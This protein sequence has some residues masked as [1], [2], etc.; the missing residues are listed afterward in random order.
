M[1]TVGWGV[2]R[3]E[4]SQELTATGTEGGDRNLILR[5]EEQHR[6]APALVKVSPWGD[7]AGNPV[8]KSSLLQPH[9][10]VL[11]PTRRRRNGSRG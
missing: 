8:G 3:L 10:H 6:A 2:G 9:Q 1:G 5:T 4:L 11:S 7:R